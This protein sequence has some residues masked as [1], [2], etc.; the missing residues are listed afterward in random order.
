MPINPERIAKLEEQA[1]QFD[2]DIQELK[3]AYQRVRNDIHASELESS[4]MSG[5]IVNIE[6]ILLDMAK[7]KLRMVDIVILVIG[8]AIGATSAYAA[9]QNNNLT[10]VM[11]QIEKGINK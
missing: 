6:N 5:K 1:K 9:I 7:R 3:E 4:K 11:I 10:R 2:C 8:L